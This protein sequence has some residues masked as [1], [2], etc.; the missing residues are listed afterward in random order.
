MLF[1]GNSH[2]VFLI[3][4]KKMVRKM[5]MKNRIIDYMEQKKIE[6]EPLC[7]QLKLSRDKLDKTSDSD[8]SGEELLKICLYLKVD[9]YDFY[10]EIG[11]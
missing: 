9:P 7:R 3:V 5:K 8:W 2:S 1:L 10:E 6:K 11:K 4:L